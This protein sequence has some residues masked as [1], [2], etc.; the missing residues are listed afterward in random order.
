[1]SKDAKAAAPAQRTIP[2]G[3]KGRGLEVMAVGK[4]LYQVF[5]LETVGGAVVKRTCIYEGRDHG[6]DGK[7]QRG[8]TLAVTR[9]NLNAAIGRYMTDLS[10]LWKPS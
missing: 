8:E 5:L 3:P 1:M 2:T 4:E 10:D 6:K 9:G 7:V